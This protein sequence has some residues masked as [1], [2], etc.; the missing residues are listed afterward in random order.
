MATWIGPMVRLGAGDVTHTILVME[1]PWLLRGPCL[2]GAMGHLPAAAQGSAPLPLVYHPLVHLTPGPRVL[3]PSLPSFWDQ[4]LLLRQSTLTSLCIVVTCTR[5]HSFSLPCL[6]LSPLD[7]FIVCLSPGE[8]KHHEGKDFICC[9]LF[10][11]CCI[12]VSKERRVEY[13]AQSRPSVNI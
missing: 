13:P 9:F 2:A 1:S 3:A 5:L 11:H 10:Y 8:Y 12:L 6:I 7:L 4:V